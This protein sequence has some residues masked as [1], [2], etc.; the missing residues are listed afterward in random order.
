MHKRALDLLSCVRWPLLSK[1]FLLS[2][3]DAN[4]FIQAFVQVWWLVKKLCKCREV[5]FQH[6]S[7]CNSTRIVFCSATLSS[8]TFF[9]WH[10][11][12]QMP[13]SCILLMLCKR[14]RSWVPMPQ[15]RWHVLWKCLNGSPWM[16][17]LFTHTLMHECVYAC[18][19]LCPQAP[20]YGHRILI[21]V[22]LVN[23]LVAGQEMV[24]V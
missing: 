15:V 11:T 2:K 22:A 17:C 19:D 23:I 6:I 3:I 5:M 8:I 20:S 1:Q 9:L 13:S 14:R 10:K 21:F 18:V 4:H 7:C 12:P 24:K 16:P